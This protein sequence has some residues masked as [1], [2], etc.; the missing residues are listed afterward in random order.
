MKPHSSEA[1]TPG[2]AYGMKIA[3]R[4]NLLAREPAWSRSS[5]KRSASPSVSGTLIRP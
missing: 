4:A 3:V 1:V 5:A 2:T